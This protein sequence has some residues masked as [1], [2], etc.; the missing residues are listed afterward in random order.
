MAELPS[1]AVAGIIQKP[2]G[3]LC[4][5]LSRRDRPKSHCSISREGLKGYGDIATAIF[6]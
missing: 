2:G 5:S 1:Y 3:V 4:N 6:S